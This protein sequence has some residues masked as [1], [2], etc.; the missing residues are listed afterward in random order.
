MSDAL[1]E[2]TTATIAISGQSQTLIAT[3]E[4]VKF[5]GFLKVYLEASDDEDEE[6]ESGVLPPLN[7]G[8]KLE[9]HEMKAAQSFS[10]P[11]ARYTEASL[12]KKLEE[13]GIGRPST[14]APTISTIQKRNYVEKENREGKER[15]ATEITLRKGKVTSKIKKEIYGAEKAKLFPT[16][17]AMI[18][19]DFLVGHFPNVIDFGFT[20]KVEEE[21]DHIA[22]GSLP[23][24]AM[25]GNFYKG[26]RHTVETTEEE[27]GPVN[28]GRELGTD[29]KTG[30][31]I[32]ARL[33]KYGPFVQIGEVVE[34]EEKP[35]Y[36]SLKKGQLLESITLEEA[37]ELFKLPRQAGE[38]E[39]KVMTVAIGRFGPYIRHDGKFYSLGKEDDPMSITQERCVELIEAK[40]KADSEKTIKVFAEDESVKV[41]NGRYGP[42]I[43]VGDKNVKIPKDKEP[44]D[45][46]LEE[47]LALAETAPEPKKKFFKKTTVAEVKKKVTAKKA[48]AK[49][50]APKKK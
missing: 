17:L 25:I 39:D 18:V 50:A 9:L 46:T 41:L 44:K 15:D 5:E 13:L 19:N 11:A 38:F 3:G 7:I 34:G 21:F 14:Y 49:K 37:L 27:K 16:D 26:F 22:E 20:A 4:V 12:V 2:K 47:C 42:Y 1:L 30:K 32:S 40:R 29:P 45:L 33:G 35:Q 48:P 10:R 31:K 6:E 24:D 28:T 36:A 8:Q 23:W 43:V